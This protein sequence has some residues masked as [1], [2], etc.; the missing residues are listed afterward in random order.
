MRAT[1]NINII[2]S[3]LTGNRDNTDHKKVSKTLSVQFLISLNSNNRKNITWTPHLW[4]ITPRTI[5]QLQI[6]SIF[7]TKLIQRLLNP[8][9]IKIPQ[10]Q[11]MILEENFD[12]II[13]RYRILYSGAMLYIFKP[14]TCKK[15]RL[16]FSENQ[17]NRINVP[18][19]V[20]DNSSDPHSIHMWFID[21]V[22][23][24]TWVTPFRVL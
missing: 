13:S 4:T 22:W 23:W 19:L 21:W 17:K 1:K 5:I 6:M 15:F 14:H 11:T 24:L 12:T 2:I 7:I 3:K 16:K 18:T 20:Q 8:H 9:T 10:I